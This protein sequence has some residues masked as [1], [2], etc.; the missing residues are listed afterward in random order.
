MKKL[1]LTVGTMAAMATGAFAQGYV[2]LANSPTLLFSTNSATWSQGGNVSAINGAA[3][4]SA[5][6]AAN[7]LFAVLV[8][9]ALSDTNVWDGTW[10]YSGVLDTNNVV[11][12]AAGRVTGELGYQA[13]INWAVGQTQN[14][15]I[16][17]WSSALA[18][19]WLAIS[20]MAAS[21]FAGNNTAG[22][23]GVSGTGFI[24][25]AASGGPFPSIW[26]T[27][28]PQAYGTPI[29]SG[30]EMFAVPVPEPSTIALAGLGGLSLLLFRRRK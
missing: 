5:A 27:I 28:G 26:S 4:A 29:G 13:P 25:A 6:G 10:S 12:G 20:N 18:T 16:V 15:I 17:G 21:G 1:I 9:G 14:C 3:P 2:S 11:S 8:G 24:Q 7:Y 23:F 30:F 19:S 22:F